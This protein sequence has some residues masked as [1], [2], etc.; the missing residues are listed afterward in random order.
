MKN[1]AR[2]QD[3]WLFKSFGPKLPRTSFRAPGTKYYSL[4][5]K[6]FVHVKFHKI[7]HKT[8]P[9]FHDL[10]NFWQSYEDLIPENYKK[11]PSKILFLVLF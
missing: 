10:D 1:E 6:F 3:L 11:N 8:C 9:Y 2:F 4:G 5:I 7:L